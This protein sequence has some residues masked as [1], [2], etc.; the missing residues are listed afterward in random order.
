MVGIQPQR[1]KPIPNDVFLRW[2]ASDVGLSE[3]DGINV[4]GGCHNGDQL[5]RRWLG[6]PV[7]LPP[8]RQARVLTGVFF[9]W[10]TGNLTTKVTDEGDL[11]RE[12]LIFLIR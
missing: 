11:Q 5:G 6:L 7:L 12:N 2:P 8:G 10:R 9:R 1:Q 3:F 4:R